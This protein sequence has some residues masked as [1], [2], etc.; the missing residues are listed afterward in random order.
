M[1]HV[2]RL[3]ESTEA[4]AYEWRAMCSGRRDG[5]GTWRGSQQGNKAGWPASSACQGR[6]V[7]RVMNETE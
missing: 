4:R 2:Q 3:S 5:T 6:G 7:R 1:V